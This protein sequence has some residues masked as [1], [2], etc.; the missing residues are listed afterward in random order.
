[1]KHTLAIIFALFLL[2]LA[3]CASPRQ[4]DDPRRDVGGSVEPI[5]TDGGPGR[6][7]VA[8]DAGT[9]V[10]RDAD[11]VQAVDSGFAIIPARLAPS[12]ADGRSG[13]Y[14]IRGGH[15]SQEPGAGRS[16]RYRIRGGF[17]P[18]TP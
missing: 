18:F 17:T 14:R 1:M 16:G 9:V 13:A 5:R 6:A 15:R 4:A 11:V 8:V 2:A 12:G 3:A 10:A 7:D